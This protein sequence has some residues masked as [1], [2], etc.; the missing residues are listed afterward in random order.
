MQATKGDQETSSGQGQKRI[1]PKIEAV[2]KRAKEIFSK[3]QSPVSSNDDDDDPD[4]SYK[5]PSTQEKYALQKL[6][7]GS[8][9]TE[10]EIATLKKQIELLQ[11]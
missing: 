9:S 1:D 7:S 2:A 3:I 10:N 8:T 6:F 5:T 11:K 4:L